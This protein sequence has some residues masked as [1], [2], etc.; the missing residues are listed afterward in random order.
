MGSWGGVTLTGETM[1]TGKEGCPCKKSSCGLAMSA[2]VPVPPVP[3]PHYPYLLR[4]HSS[5]S[6]SLSII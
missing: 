5:S 4:S 2:G 3:L 6:I 1:G